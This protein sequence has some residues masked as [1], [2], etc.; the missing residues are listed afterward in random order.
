MY[1]KGDSLEVEV[2]NITKFGAFVVDEKKVKGLIH[3]SEVSSYFVPD[4]TKVFNVGDIIE[5]TILG[6][7]N[8]KNQLQ[9]SYKALNSSQKFKR[10]FK[11]NEE[12]ESVMTKLNESIKPTK[13]RLGIKND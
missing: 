13:K 2:T 3:I 9:L 11:Q 8:D 5:V 4:I 1:K 10:D 7:D 6:F 12:F